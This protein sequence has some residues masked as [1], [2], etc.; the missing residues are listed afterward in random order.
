MHRIMSAEA[1]N[2]IRFSHNSNSLLKIKAKSVT[3]TMSI[4]NITRMVSFNPKR[5]RHSANI[6]KR[7]KNAKTKPFAFKRARV[8]PPLSPSPVPTTGGQPSRLPSF[9]PSATVS[10]P[11]SQPPPS[12]PPTVT[13]K[14]DASSTSSDPFLPFTF[15]R[16]RPCVVEHNDEILVDFAAMWME[17]DPFFSATTTTA[18]ST[19]SSKNAAAATPDAIME[20]PLMEMPV[21][22]I[23]DTVSVVSLENAEE[24][25]SQSQQKCSSPFMSAIWEIDTFMDAVVPQEME[26]LRI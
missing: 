4:N 9:S 1:K 6:R 5:S 12:R 23:E 2:S 11:T 25:R 20:M 8:S 3:N 7:A 21:L 16:S 24:E 10:R 19:T 15:K 22:E 26:P 18:R 13:N 17:T 14:D